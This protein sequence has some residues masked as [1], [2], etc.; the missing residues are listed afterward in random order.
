MRFGI[1]VGNSGPEA[2]AQ[3][4]VAQAKAADDSGYDSVWVSDHVVIPERFR[5]RYPF[6][7]KPFT[8]DSVGRY[9][10]PLITLAVLAGATSRVRLGTSVLII[11]QRNPLVMA[12]EIAT[13]DELSGGRV[14]LGI[15][16]GWL[17]EEFEALDAKFEGRGSVLEEWLQIFRTVWSQ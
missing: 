14:D 1:H 16:A 2:T 5:S 11:P 6:R 15:G 12:K 7:G 4:M 13:L 3:S 9:Y 8:P 10:E 17:A